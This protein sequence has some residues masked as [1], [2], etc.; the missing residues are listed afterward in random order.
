MNLSMSF[1]DMFSTSYASICG[2]LVVLVTIFNLRN[3]GRRPKG[4]PPGPR[5]MPLIGNLH[6]M[7]QKD[8]HLQFKKWAEE[9]G[10]RSRYPVS[11]LPMKT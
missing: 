1:F 6:Q 4:L 7:P 10:Y 11:K 9:F 5:T 8:P 3:V 2:L